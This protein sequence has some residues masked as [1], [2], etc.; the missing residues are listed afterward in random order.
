M[1]S[2]IAILR[3][4]KPDEAADIARALV[5]GGITRIEVP[6]NSPSPLQSI[7]NMVEAVG[8]EAEIG[9]G[10]VLT[11]EQVAEVKAAGGTFVVSPNCDI[12]VIAATVAAGMGSYPGVLTP[13][14]CFAALKAG[15]TAIKV[16]PGHLLGLAGLKAVRAVLPPETEVYIVGGVKPDAFADWFAAGAT[17]FGMGS[18]LYKPGDTAEIVGERARTIIGALPAA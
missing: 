18:N 5:E 8:T 13:T 7:A 9:A 12:E 16:F 14:E 2:I 6:L 1:K 11:P 17:G 10:T 4:I 15:A 3:G